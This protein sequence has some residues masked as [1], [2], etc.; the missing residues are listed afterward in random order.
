MPKDSPRA[1][2]HRRTKRDASQS[3]KQLKIALQQHANTLFTLFAVLAQNGGE[4][5][6]T[7]GTMLQVIKDQRSLQFV[8]E[9]S[10][11]DT[12]VLVVRLVHTGVA[13]E[14]DPPVEEE[15]PLPFV[16]DEQDR[17]KENNLP[18][19]VTRAE[20]APDYRG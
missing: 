11:T 14:E 20:D 9:P 7:H 12:Q 10:P 13:V 1:R 5:Y 18:E 17:E 6:I 3:R 19:Y 16:D 8:T 4:S 15:P 2:K